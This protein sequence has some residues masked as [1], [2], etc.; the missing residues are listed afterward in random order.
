[1][2][3]SSNLRMLAC[4]NQR[5]NNQLLDV[6]QQLSEEQLHQDRQ[7][8]FPS[9][10]A[11]WNHILFGDLIMLQR[12]VDNEIVTIDPQ[13]LAELP[14]SKRITDT[15]VTTMDELRTLRTKVDDIYLTMTK[16][17]TDQDCNKTVRYITTAGQVIER[18]VGEF[19]Q[20]V[21]NHQTHHRGR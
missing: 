9:I 12:L 21:F 18:R 14:T 2:D 11:H 5:M 10:M 17:F 15:F 20:H 6:C 19:C 7:A 3:L 13:L 16:N 1:M 8:F 4:Y